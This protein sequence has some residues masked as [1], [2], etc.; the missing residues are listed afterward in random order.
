MKILYLWI[1]SSENDFI[2]KQ[3]FNISGKYFWEFNKETKVLTSRKK[4]GYIENFWCKDGIEDL[5]VIVGINASGKSTLLY[6]IVEWDFIIVP[7]SNENAAMRSDRRRKLVVFEE[8]DILYYYHNLEYEVNIDPSIVKRK[9]T[10][11]IES[12][13][14]FVS[15]S[16]NYLSKSDLLLNY[17]LSDHNIKEHVKELYEKFKIPVSVLSPQKWCNLKSYDVPELKVKK[18]LHRERA[19][20]LRNTINIDKNAYQD[21]NNLI[22]L[23]FFV[24]SKC[25]N[26]F[27]KTFQYVTVDFK[28]FSEIY[29]VEESIEKLKTDI[30]FQQIFNL[31]HKEGNFNFKM[32]MIYFLYE[33]MFYYEGESIFEV[34]EIS[35]EQIE[36]IHQNLLEIVFNEKNDVDKEEITIEEYFLNATEDLMLFYKLTKENTNSVIHLDLDNNQEFLDRLLFFFE[37]GIPSFF[38]RYL[39]VEFERMSSGEEALLNLYSRIFWAYNAQ[40]C[41]KESL[42]LIDEIDLYMHPKWQRGLI[43]YLIEDIPNLIGKENK[44]QIIITTHSPIILSDIPKSNILFLENKDG[45][46]VVSDNEKH[47]DTFGNNVHTLFLDSFFLSDEGTMGAFAEDKINKIIDILM[48]KE[49]VND[50]DNSILNT[51][52]IIGDELIRNKL[53]EVYNQKVNR[54]V[55]IYKEKSQKEIDAIDESIVAL[56]KQISSMEKTV[57]KLE[58]LKR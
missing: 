18:M 35:I 32:L 3:G 57:A 33:F 29:G 7:Q 53:L 48:N 49:D 36:K 55:P 13:K 14:I 27:G 45:K 41:K 46:C 28:K 38:I 15:N 47:R 52:K 2:Q 12:T 6:E 58:Q 43:S 34:S 25:K 9:R 26:Y 23:Y 17:N 42:I 1:D 40:G 22:R 31:K 20:E 24:K 51:I 30:T 54:E 37:S 16:K 50:E 11:L 56:K 4:E 10:I 44:A 21:M 39:R 8:N 5:S 19:I